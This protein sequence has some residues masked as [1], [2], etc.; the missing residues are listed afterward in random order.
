MQENI[1]HIFFLLRYAVLTRDYY[2]RTVT[3]E[4]SHLKS[5][6]LNIEEYRKKK[7]KYLNHAKLTRA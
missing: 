2:V 5:I 6:K 1:I 3:K 7:K 4:T